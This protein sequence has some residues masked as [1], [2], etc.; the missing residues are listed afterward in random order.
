MSEHADIITTSN[1]LNSQQAATFLGVSKAF[2]ERDRCKKLPVIPYIRLSA[3]A[4][5]YRK[6]DL[7][8]F[9]S[10]NLIGYVGVNVC[11]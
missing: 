8:A 6:E 10:K 11:L 2:L 9:T 5:R 1:L 3:R 7:L 4:I